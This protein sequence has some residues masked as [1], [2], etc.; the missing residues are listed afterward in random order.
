ML[1]GSTEAVRRE[2][3]GV[4]DGLSFA[5]QRGQTGESK[6]ERDTSEQ[7]NGGREMNLRSITPEQLI[8]PSFLPAY[9]SDIAV[10]FQQLSQL[11]PVVFLLDRIGS[12][13]N[14]VGN[15]SA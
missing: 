11:N 13:L 1:N 8:E 12:S 9:K 10:L 3:E 15:S 7:S 2:F 6:K 5:T 4:I 14:R